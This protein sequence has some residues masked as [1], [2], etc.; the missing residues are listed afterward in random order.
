MTKDN[1]PQKYHI[2]EDTT[3]SSDEVMALTKEFNLNF[4]ETFRALADA[5]TE[6]PEKLIQMQQHLPEG[7]DP[8]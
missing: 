4:K 3:A 2:P 1:P 8:L 6:E 5:T 7:I